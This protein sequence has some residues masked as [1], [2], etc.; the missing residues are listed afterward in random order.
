MPQFLNIVVVAQKGLKPILHMNLASMAA[1][2]L[3]ENRMLFSVGTYY[4][5]FALL[6]GVI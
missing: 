6:L 3:G 2:Y 5:L 4:A 1:C